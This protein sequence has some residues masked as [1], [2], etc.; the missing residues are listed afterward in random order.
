MQRSFLK[1]FAIILL[2]N[3]LLIEK[4]RAMLMTLDVIQI[5]E[6]IDK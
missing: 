3:Q 4:I 1:E 2:K 6:Q 5:L